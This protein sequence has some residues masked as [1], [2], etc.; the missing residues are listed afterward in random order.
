MEELF[1]LG[2]SEIEVQNMLIAC[3]EISELEKEEI[4]DSINILRTVKCN[5]RHIRNILICNPAYLKRSPLDILN[6]I[7]KLL[8]L[9]IECIHLLFDTN[10]YLLNKDDYEIAQY[11]SEQIKLGKELKDIISD[12]ESNPFIIDE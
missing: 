6:L 9:N 12:F 5:E 3:P 1:N 10:P 11:I 4:T 7:K 8:E 2:L